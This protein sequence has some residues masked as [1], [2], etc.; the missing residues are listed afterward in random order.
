MAKN[1]RATE[2]T[3]RERFEQGGRF[4]LR[5]V[6]VGVAIAAVVIAGVVTATVLATRT[7]A[8]GGEVVAT[9]GGDYSGV[10]VQMVRLADPVLTENTIQLSLADIKQS[11]IGGVIYERSTPMPAGYDDIGTNGLPVLAYVSPSGRLVVASSLCE[12][13]HSYDFHIEG[14]D[15]VCNACYTHWDLNT[16]EGISG[17]CLTYPPSE[18][19]A[20]VTGDTV[21][22]QRSELEGWLP[23]I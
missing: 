3:K 23:R 6:L 2:L 19:K 10:S 21:E 22:I 18:L 16:L 12:P 15:L 11:K 14:N 9:E 20:T 8:A 7:P 17:G 4:P 1:N 13:C 5:K